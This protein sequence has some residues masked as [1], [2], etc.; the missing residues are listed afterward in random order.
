M[1]T[2]RAAVAALSLA[3]AVAV[4]ATVAVLRSH[5]DDPDA[6]HVT[7]VPPTRTRP[8]APASPNLPG[9]QVVDDDAAGLRYEVPSNWALAPETETLESS[10]GAVL[11]HLA[12]F[13]TYLCQGAEYGRAFAGS[14]RVDG[15]PAEVAAELAAAIAADQYS[16]GSQTAKVTLSR[17]TPIVRDGARGTLIRAD[18]EVTAGEVADRCASTRGVVTVV[19]LATAAGTAVVVL[20]ADTDDRGDTAPTASGDDLRGMADSVRPRR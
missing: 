19:A 4:L 20:S 5:E 6:P 2:Q 11:T 18:A 15:D 12:D 14:G 3:A 1:R 7:A 8:A 9:W 10:S 17:P 16:D 13:G